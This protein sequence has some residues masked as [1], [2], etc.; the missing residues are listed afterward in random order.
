M[1][2]NKIVFIINKFKLGGAETLVALQAKTIAKYGWIPEVISLYQNDSKNDLFNKICPDVICH[3]LNFRS[4]FS[5]YE[6]WRL[7]KILR[8]RHFNAMITNLFDANLVGR[9]I[10][11]L[12]RVPVILSY[13]H[14][15]YPDKKTWQIFADR[16]LSLKT[17]RILVG[18]SQVKEF[19]IEQENIPSSKF[20]INQNS[21]DLVFD[22][23]KENRNII[24]NKLSLPKDYL[25]FVTAG[26]LVEQKGHIY[27][28]K[29]VKSIKKNNAKIKFLIFGEGVLR[30]SLIDYIKENDLADVVSILP[31]T[32]MKDILA[33]SD[34]FVLPSLW[35][36]LS[37]ALVSAMNAG[38]PILGTRI[39][40]TLDV[41][42]DEENGV[43]VPPGDSESL[44]KEIMRLYSEENL[45]KKIGDQAKIDSK[46]FSIEKN[47]ERI[48]GILRE[49]VKS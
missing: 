40:G 37:L 13:E 11:V 24:L 16:L 4:I 9:I 25:Y 2:K 30:D 38:C 12:A 15:Q 19:T 10:G 31:P 5:F 49:V 35:E 20:F 33:I 7:Y 48:I 42:S 39:S 46:N 27:L 22:N 17:D 21:I 23:V 6:W 1:E 34:V 28:L 43:L 18:S 41:I 26:R 8:K 36:G 3:Q 47:I 29:A 45:R 14:S 44:A 32:E